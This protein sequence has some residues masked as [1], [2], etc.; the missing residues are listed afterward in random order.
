MAKADTSRSVGMERADLRRLLKIAIQEPVSAALALGGDSKAI[1]MLD[2]IKQPRALEKSIKDGAPDSKNHRFGVVTVDPDDPKLARF[3]INRAASGMAKRLVIALKGTGYSKVRILLE[4]GSDVEAAEGEPDEATDDL[5]A[6]D[7]DGDQGEVATA[8]HV[9]PNDLLEPPSLKP[10]DAG[11]ATTEVPDQPSEAGGHA[12]DAASLGA[13]LTDLVK[14]MMQVIAA[15]PSQKSALVELAT[16]A[17]AS[18]KRGD[19]QQAAAGIE[20][21]RQALDNGGAGQ[22]AQDSSSSTSALPPSDDDA[23]VNDDDDDEDDSDDTTADD[24]KT[25]TQADGDDPDVTPAA[26]SQS[27][28]DG[29]VVS[30]SAPDTTS[31]TATLTTLVKQ[32]LPLIAA[33]PSQADALKSL[34]TQAQAALKSGDLDTANGHVVSLQGLLNGGSGAPGSVPA[35]TAPNGDSMSNATAASAPAIAKARMAWVATRQRVEGDL[36]KLH[37]AFT[38]ALKGHSMEQELTRTF[39]NRV[40]TVLDKLGAQLS[41]KLDAINQAT[42]PTQRAKLVQDAHALI[43]GYQAHVDSDETIGLLDQN[44]FTPMSVQKTMTTTL[45]ALAKAIR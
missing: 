11:A 19:T 5:N 41:D 44:P 32:A 18:L 40:D 23:E 29:N 15:D 42:D 43:A 1:I 4:D 22:T 28:S 13:T 17:Q 45:S 6:S 37:G 39:R 26:A 2:K 3:V 24:A 9:D 16:D 27:D 20:I 10:N 25:A 12:P 30:A 36:G 7:D 8:R 35:G 31:L 14:R 21:L 34:M 33:D 38:S